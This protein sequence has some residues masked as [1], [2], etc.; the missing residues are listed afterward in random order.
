LIERAGATAPA[1]EPTAPVA[2]ATPAA[3]AIAAFPPLSGLYVHVPF[4]AQ[5]CAYCDFAREIAREDRIERYLAA[6]AREVELA[7]PAGF[8][9]DTVFFGGGTPSVLTPAHWRRLMQALERRVDF[10]RARE[11]TI[12][13]NPGTLDAGKLDAWQAAGVNRISFGAQT[14]D[15]AQLLVLGRIHTREEIPAAVAFARQAGLANASIDLIYGL[16]GQT[17]ADF[18]QSL[19]AA[20]ALPITH[21]SAYA[22][23]YEPGTP[24]HV[25]RE[26]GRLTPC[27][28][29][30]VGAMYRRAM[31]YLAGAGFEQYEISNYSRGRGHAAVHNLVYW[32]R[33]RCLAI[34]PSASS[35]QDGRRR[36][37][38]RDLGRWAEAL[39]AGRRPEAVEEELTGP[40]AAGEA[41]VLRLRLNEGVDL[42]E[43]A[44]VF[45]R[46]PTAGLADRIV[47]WQRLG[48]VEY[49]PGQLLRLTAA[50]RPVADAMLCEFVQC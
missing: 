45:G 9:P 32:H 15:P 4:C 6:A 17:L 24:F 10:S 28:E 22:L 19:E 7:L 49:R 27:D 29:D 48:L 5:I 11:V 26:Q 12:E 39:E 1:A 41:F 38:G 36:T 50:G 44:R 25:L 13:C 2:D 20:Q 23:T 30:L 42:A 35:L 34:G 3:A 40:A 18:E 16:P 47:L 8:A 33:R 31:E 43:F 37:T 21:L 14:F 46:D